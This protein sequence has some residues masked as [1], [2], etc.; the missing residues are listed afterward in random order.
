MVA[1]FGAITLIFVKESYLPLLLSRRAAKIRFETKNWAIHAK[2]DEQK[3]DLR[4]IMVK[5]LFRPFRML[6]LEPILVVLTIYM[7][8]I[9]GFLYLFFESYPVSF[10][11]QRGYNDGVSALPFL[12]ITVG[13]IVGGST[14]TWL[15]ITRFARKLK[16]HGKVVPEERLPPMIV[17]AI[18]LPAGLFWSGWT[19]SPHISWVPEVLAG[20]PIGAGVLIIFIQGINYIIGTYFQ[21]ISR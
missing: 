3:T 7:A 9:Y 5:Y 16:E 11:E 6:F 21:T 20:M 2:S 17:G 4:E 12:G 18:M 19:S 14:I 10:Q 1:F 15:T 13:I 8:L